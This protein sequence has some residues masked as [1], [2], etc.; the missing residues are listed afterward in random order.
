MLLPALGQTDELVCIQ[1]LDTDQQITIPKSRYL[2]GK[3]SKYRN[4]RLA[5]AA[6]FIQP[7]LCISQFLSCQAGRHSQKGE[8]T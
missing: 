5:G 6:E 3:S 8:S 4:W 7:E 2:S 1:Y